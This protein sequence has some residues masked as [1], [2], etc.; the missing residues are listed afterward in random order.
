MGVWH[1]Y[2]LAAWPCLKLRDEFP[3][4]AESSQAATAAAQVTWRRLRGLRVMITTLGGIKNC[5]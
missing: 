3:D 5:G 1:G 4:S 2:P